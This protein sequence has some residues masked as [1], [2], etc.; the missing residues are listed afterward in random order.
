MFFFPCPH[1]SVQQW[2]GDLKSLLMWKDIWAAVV[3]LGTRT[4]LDNVCIMVA[5]V[6]GGSAKGL[7]PV[8]EL[9][10]TTSRMNDAF[11][12]EWLF[13]HSFERVK[14]GLIN[15]HAARR[16]HCNLYLWECV[17]VTAFLAYTS[18]SSVPVINTRTHIYLT[19]CLFV[20]VYLSQLWYYH[21]C[22]GVPK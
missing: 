8:N 2:Q 20:L 17:W 19:I 16:E 13:S 10:L 15:C 4:H 22:P 3:C 6:I 5:L 21:R 7:N 12:A 11:T 14:C 9:W 1:L 18:S